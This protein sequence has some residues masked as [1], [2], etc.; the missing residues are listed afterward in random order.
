MA[1]RPPFQTTAFNVD[2][3]AHTCQ[4]Q[5]DGHRRVWVDH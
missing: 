1:N 5:K 3:Q 4:L 2:F